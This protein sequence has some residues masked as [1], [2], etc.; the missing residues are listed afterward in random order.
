MCGQPFA[1]RRPLSL[2]LSLW[3]Y[4]VP[5]TLL[6]ALA[7][8]DVSFGTLR[9][10]VFPASTRQLWFVSD[11]LLLLLCTP[12]LARLLHGLPRRAHRGLLLALAVPLIVYPTLFGEDGPVSDLVW[13]FLYEYLLAAYLRRYPGNRLSALLRRRGVA[14]ALGTGLPLLNTAARAWLEWQGRTG[15]K[16]FQY[17]AYYRNQDGGIGRFSWVNDTMLEDLED[18]QARRLRRCASSS[19]SYCSASARALIATT[20]YR[21]P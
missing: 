2:W 7:G 16:A 19:G 4:T 11:Y 21:S 3:L 10:A 12:L 1:T 5:V 17:V 9:W 18:Y 14:L 13:M 6:C 20:L 8:L 15:G